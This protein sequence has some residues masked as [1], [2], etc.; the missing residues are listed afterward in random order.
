MLNA[1]R[2]L[3]T[4]KHVDLK[5]GNSEQDNDSWQAKFRKL[6]SS[7]KRR[8]DELVEKLATA[9]KEY[10]S[11]MYGLT[12]ENEI[13]KKLL[14]KAEQ[15]FEA[16]KDKIQSVKENSNQL[17]QKT[18]ARY[19]TELSNFQAELIVEREQSNKGVLEREELKERLIER[20]RLIEIMEEECMATKANIAEMNDV[21]KNLGHE[22]VQAGTELHE[23]VNKHQNEIEKI[24]LEHTHQIEKKILPSG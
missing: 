24:N 18:I 10:C 7:S 6:E 16:A 3:S 15:D 1:L 22:L 8:V 9:E 2:K 20:E 19:S 17:L 11:K 12:E 14:K 13:L 4:K 23:C 5:R 21:N